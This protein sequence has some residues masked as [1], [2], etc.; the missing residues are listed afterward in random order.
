VNPKSIVRE[1][2]RKAPEPP[3]FRATKGAWIKPAWVVR[4]MVEQ[5]GWSASDAV[6][7]VIARMN[8]HPRDVAFAGIR[9]AYYEVRKKD[10]KKEAK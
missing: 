2:Q 1:I 8:L 9:A 7:E 10:W 6:R 4:R 5:Q 3:R